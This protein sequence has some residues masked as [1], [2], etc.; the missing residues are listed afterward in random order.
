M[1]SAP[2][3]DNNYYLNGVI[4]DSTAINIS[5]LSSYYAFGQ[6][7]FASGTSP[8]SDGIGKGRAVNY[9]SNVTGTLTTQLKSPLGQGI[10]QP[11]IYGN[12]VKPSTS[13]TLMDGIPQGWVGSDNWSGCNAHA[14]ATPSGFIYGES[15]YYL[16]PLAKGGFPMTPTKT[17]WTPAEVND[18]TFGVGVSQT[19]VFTN[20][21][22]P[23]LAPQT[24]PFAIGGISVAVYYT[25]GIVGNPFANCNGVEFR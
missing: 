15:D 25:G 17:T 11:N 3:P 18:V 20:T 2:W 9:F 24:I 23:V 10:G 12:G 5:H 4:Q 22:E 1:P 16:G 7:A 21:Y 6:P 14:G 8:V 19:A 13:S